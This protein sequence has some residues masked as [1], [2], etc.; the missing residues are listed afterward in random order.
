MAGANDES[1]NPQGLPARPRAAR[2]GRPR[3][4]NERSE[5]VAS[6]MMAGATGIEPAPLRRE[7][8]WNYNFFLIFNML[9]N[10]KLKCARS[11][12]PFSQPALH[13]PS[14]SVSGDK[15]NLSCPLITG[16]RFLNFSGTTKAW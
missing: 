3:G 14:G 6:E 8:R 12:S 1:L 11:V 7:C 16:L 10:R 4:D 5:F 9:L 13:L 2:P 15:T